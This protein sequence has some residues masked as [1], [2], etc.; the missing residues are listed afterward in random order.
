MVPSI[1]GNQDK[2]TVPPAQGPAPESNPQ[3]RPL[4]INEYP[5]SLS[6]IFRNRQNLEWEV[7]QG[8][9]GGS[10]R[11]RGGYQ[12]AMWSLLAAMIDMLLLLGMCCV[13]LIVFLKIVHTPMTKSLFL[14][15][16]IVFILGSWMYMTVTRFFIGASLGEATCDLRLGRPQDR[17]SSIYFVKVLLRTTLVVITGICTLPLVSLAIGKDVAGSLTGV[18]LFSL[19]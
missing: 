4:E 11:R 13:F 14:D 6:R 3:P 2:A 19:K 1:D 16:S 8:F 18:K 9:Q 12:L 10:Q 15:F 7:K 17:L 5:E